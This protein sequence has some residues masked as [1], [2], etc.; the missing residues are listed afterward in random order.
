MF[1]ELAELSSGAGGEWSEAGN[2]REECQRPHL[3]GVRFVVGDLRPVSR[4]LAAGMSGERL[5][6]GVLPWS[7]VDTCSS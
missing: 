7:R 1:A 3:N 6:W 4:A 2:R 5:E